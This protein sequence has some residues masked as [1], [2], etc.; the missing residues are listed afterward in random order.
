MYVCSR[1]KTEYDVIP[2]NGKCRECNSR[3]FYKKR[4]PILKKIKAY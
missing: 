3:I 2:E 1:C 4:E